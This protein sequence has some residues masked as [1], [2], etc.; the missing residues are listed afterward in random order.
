MTT[1]KPKIDPGDALINQAVDKIKQKPRDEAE[2]QKT[3]EDFEALFVNFLL[4]SMRKTVMK[5][6]L[7][8]TGLGGEIWQGV[9][10]SELSRVVA[11]NRQ[12][13]IAEMLVK[14]LSQQLPT[15]PPDGE[16][17]FRPIDPASLKVRAQKSYSNIQAANPL[18]KFDP[19]IHSAA[20]KHGVDPALVRSVIMAESAGN[21]QAVSSKNARGLMQ[22]IDS[23][24][25]E[26]GVKNPHDPKENIEGGT[27]YLRQM[28]DKFNGNLHLALAAYNA[29]PGNV[30]KYNGIPPFK[31]TREYVNRVMTYYKKFKNSI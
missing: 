19:L 2:L 6:G 31:E 27:K 23:T 10:D 3:A 4:K 25:T 12:L 8:D 17:K 30:Q 22:L 16:P 11:K 20:K 15:S 21:P 13:G 14:Q 26:M 1:I 28:L 29:G 9:F 24:A 7:L 18:K 5:S